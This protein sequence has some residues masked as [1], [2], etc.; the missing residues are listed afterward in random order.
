MKIPEKGDANLSGVNDDLDMD[1]YWPQ[2]LTAG[3][4]YKV[5]P[6]FTFGFSLKWSDWSRFD[7]SK[8][9]FGRFTFLKT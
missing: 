7:R 2:M 3:I 1:F 5:T 6:D 4:G 9:E 8:S